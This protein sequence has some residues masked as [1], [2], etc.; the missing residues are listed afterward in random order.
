VWFKIAL[1]IERG[2]GEIVWLPSQTLSYHRAV[3]YT[4]PFF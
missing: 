4:G 3:R 1:H 2:N